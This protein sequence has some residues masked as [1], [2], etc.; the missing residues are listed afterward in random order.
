MGEATALTLVAEHLAIGDSI[1][2]VMRMRNFFKDQ[3]IVWGIFKNQA[4]QI[5]NELQIPFTVEALLFWQFINESKKQEKEIAL[6]AEQQISYLLEQSAHQALDKYLDQPEQ[7][8]VIWKKVRGGFVKT[9]EADPI[10][11][12]TKNAGK[13]GAQLKRQVKESYAQFNYHIPWEKAVGLKEDIKQ[14]MRTL[15]Y[16]LP[17]ISCKHFQDL[18]REAMQHCEQEL[19]KVQEKVDYSEIVP[20]ILPALSPQL[21]IY[22]PSFCSFLQSGKFSTT[23]R[24]LFQTQELTEQLFF[25]HR[26]IKTAKKSGVSL[27]QEY[28]KAAQYF[29]LICERE[30]L[31]VV[32]IS[33]QEATF[34]QEQLIMGTRWLQKHKQQ[35]KSCPDRHVALFTADGR[36][37]QNG[38]KSLGFSDKELTDLASLEWF[39]EAIIDMGLI[40][41]RLRKK[42]FL[43]KRLKKWSNLPEFW[44]K[45]KSCQANPETAQVYM[46]DRYIAA[47]PQKKASFFSFFK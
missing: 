17:A 21:H 7:Q 6:S 38:P 13:P 11:R 34:F 8:I 30:E 45:I 15:K 42:P 4:K 14:T 12:F 35:I 24:Q 28:L 43:D 20:E 39:Q 37:A 32:A 36:L 33:D 29:L 3:K 44:K 19:K 16:C 26:L 25:S 31:I 41:C 2:G 22:H 27:N 9:F 47:L 5:E 40:S 10:K 46:I 18:S 23:A 1:Q